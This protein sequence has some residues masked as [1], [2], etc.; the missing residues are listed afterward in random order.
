MH[1]RTLILFSL[2][3]L[4][5]GCISLFLSLYVDPSL[6]ISANQSIPQETL[7]SF[8]A[9]ISSIHQSS[10]GFVVT[11]SRDQEISAFINTNDSLFSEGSLVDVSGRLEDEWFTIHSM[12]LL[13][14]EN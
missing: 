14:F 6:I 2:I 11:L 12:E 13:E 7:V 5:V 3:T 10:S 9:R 8:P 4:F 1:E